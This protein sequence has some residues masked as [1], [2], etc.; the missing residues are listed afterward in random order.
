LINEKRNYL[1]M[2]V[3]KPGKDP[4]FRGARKLVLFPDADVTLSLN[5]VEVKEG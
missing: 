4:L 1:L 2:A 5:L 3:I